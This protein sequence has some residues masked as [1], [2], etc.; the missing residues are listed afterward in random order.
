MPIFDG[1][2]PYTN[3]HSMNLDW[4]IET[5]SQI[6][7]EWDEFGYSVTANAV[8]GTYPNVEVTG[9]LIH[10]LNFKFTLVKGDKGDKGDTGAQGEEGVGIWRI[11]YINDKLYIDTTDMRTWISPSIKGD[12]GD[13]LKILGVYPTLRDLQTAHPTGLPGYMYLVGTDPDFTLYLWN[14]ST[15]SWEVGGSLT[16]PPASDSLPMMSG[17]ASAGVSSS[18]ARADHVHPSDSSK[19]SLA[20]VY[21]VG[22]IYMNV[23]NSTNPSEIFGFGT[24]VAIQ[25]MFLVG[26]SS[27]YTAGSTGGERTHA[28]TVDELPSHSHGLSQ[29]K[30]Q[31]GTGTRYGLN[32]YNERYYQDI[33]LEIPPVSGF[34][35]LTYTT[36]SAGDGDPVNNL[37]PYIAV[38]IW[39]RV[40]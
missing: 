24:W 19:P 11:R 26:A 28:L 17:T 32:P 27:T 31:T 22:S 37:P 20:D 1:N 14:N 23:S 25:N 34:T 36:D 13:G 12:P 21:P 40:A 38:Y 8:A 30:K 33:A 10:G 2:L 4:I 18:Y 15:T 16:T 39:Q 29:L 3:L 35:G 7:K 9:D 5:V 6:K